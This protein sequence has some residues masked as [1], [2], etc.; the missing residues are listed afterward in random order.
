MLKETSMPFQMQKQT[1]IDP[2][3]DTQ[4]HPE[5]RY[6]LLNSMMFT[7]LLR[8]GVLMSQGLSQSSIIS[9]S[10]TVHFDEVESSNTLEVS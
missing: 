4:L 1:K 3:V 6:L 2:K 9:T 7:D 5:Y 10:D 8:E